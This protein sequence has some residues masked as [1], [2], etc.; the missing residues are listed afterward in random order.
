MF[1]PATSESSTSA[2]PVII[3]KAFSTAVWFPPL[4]NRLPLPEAMTRGDAARRVMTAGAGDGIARAS[5]AAVPVTTNSRRLILVI[6]FGLLASGSYDRA[7]V[8][9]HRPSYTFRARQE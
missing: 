4:R 8:S 6:C 1:T 7:V 2:P 5:P 3:V 9:R